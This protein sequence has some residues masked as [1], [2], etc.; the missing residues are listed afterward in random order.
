VESWHACIS[1]VWKQLWTLN[2]ALQP[3]VQFLPHL[4]L[5]DAMQ[6]LVQGH[7]SGA[8]GAGAKPRVQRDLLPKGR[9]PPGAC[10]LVLDLPILPSCFPS[11]YQSVLL[12]IHICLWSPLLHV[13]LWGVWR[14]SRSNL[15]CNSL[16]PCWGLMARILP[17][18]Q[19]RP[20][21]REVRLP[22]TRWTYRTPRAQKGHTVIQHGNL[23]VW[24][25]LG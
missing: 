19:T 23:M 4:G 3:A 5:R 24:A 17:M 22:A 10:L 12:Q 8:A 13:S 25:S 11:W 21:Q 14:G 18:H 1:K 6:G 15:A 2:T 9:K 20:S 7:L 16:K